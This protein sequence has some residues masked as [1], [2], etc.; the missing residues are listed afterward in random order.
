MF[1]DA[2]FSHHAVIATSVLLCC[3]YVHFSSL[4]SKMGSLLASF[5]LNVKSRLNIEVHRRTYL[6]QC[7]RITFLVPLCLCVPIT[8]M[9]NIGSF[10][11][12]YHCV[13]I[14]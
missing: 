11:L 13:C 5:A 8:M 3:D 7:Y 14:Y 10:N 12:Q 1:C 4:I 9:P 6:L 2:M